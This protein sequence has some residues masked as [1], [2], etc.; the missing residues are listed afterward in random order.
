MVVATDSKLTLE[1]A[2]EL[3]IPSD[4]IILTDNYCPVDSLVPNI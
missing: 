2:I 3:N 1:N 4:T